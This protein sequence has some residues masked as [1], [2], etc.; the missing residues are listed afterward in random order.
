MLTEFAFTPSIFDENAHEDKEAWRDQLKELGRNL[1]PRVAAWPVVVS[2][3][4]AGSWNQVADQT[5]KA[6]TDQRARLLCEG[7][8]QN[9]RKTLVH[10]PSCGNWPDEDIAWGREAIAS[11][12]AEPIERIVANAATKAALLEEFQLIRSLDEV[13]D[14]GFWRGIAS[15]ASPKM[16]IADQVQLL[17]KLCLHSEWVAFINAHTSTSE[18][19]FALELVRTVFSRPTGFTEIECELHT[20]EPQNCADEADRKTRLN[21]VTHNVSNQVRRMLSGSQSV[22][23]YFWPKLLDRFL[24]AGTFTVDSNGHQRKRPRWGVSM[25]HVAR[26]SDPDAAPTEW[27]LLRREQ[28]DYWFREYVSKDTADRPTPT[29]ITQVP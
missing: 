8:L 22:D 17:R 7:I 6:I 16:I 25:N 27:K 18:S 26:S 12:N 2:D 21:N 28:L 9:M 4:Y 10:R 14:G 13:E 20:Q 23:L 19:D 11:N 3:L 15:D 29:T 5:V 1:F 24:I